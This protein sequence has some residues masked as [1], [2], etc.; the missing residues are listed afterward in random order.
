MTNLDRNFHILEEGNIWI[1]KREAEYGLKEDNDTYLFFATTS[2]DGY[3]CK[4]RAPLVPNNDYNPVEVA[5]RNIVDQVTNHLMFKPVSASEYPEVVKS[6]DDVKAC[7]LNKA[8]GVKNEFD[9][10]DFTR[11]A[12][13]IDA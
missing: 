1:G 10:R 9:T 6:Y 2:E 13:R 5:A 4:Y 7:I 8:L 11:Y 12:G 3:T